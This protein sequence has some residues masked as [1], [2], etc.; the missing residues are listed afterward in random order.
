M[1]ASAV[2]VGERFNQQAQA[3]A[4]NAEVHHTK[5]FGHAV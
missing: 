3:R 4:L 1:G 5:L 2:N